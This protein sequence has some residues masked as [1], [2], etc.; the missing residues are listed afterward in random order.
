M[1]QEGETK[2]KGREEGPQE[3]QEPDP[4]PNLKSYYKFV[5]GGTIILEKV[6]I[7]LFFELEKE[8]AM[9]HR[10]MQIAKSKRV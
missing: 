1:L 7:P 8:I 5:E 2:P 9:T 10:W 4:Q 6:A 3:L